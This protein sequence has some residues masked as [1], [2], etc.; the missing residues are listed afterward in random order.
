MEALIENCVCYDNSDEVFRLKAEN[1][2]LREA[3]KPFADFGIKSEALNQN[4]VK[5]TYVH[6]D[7]GMLTFA[8]FWRARAALEAK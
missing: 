6:G 7:I 1:D 4:W 8:D 3:L 2:R 5:L